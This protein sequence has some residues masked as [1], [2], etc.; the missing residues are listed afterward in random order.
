MDVAIRAMKT[1]QRGEEMLEEKQQEL[2]EFHG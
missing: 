1:S 2:T